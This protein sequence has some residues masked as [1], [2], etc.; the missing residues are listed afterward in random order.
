V[1][2]L[3]LALY[4]IRNFT[5]LTRLA[6]KP[7]LNLI[8][9]GNGSGKS[10]VCD[11]LLS[12]LA[13]ISDATVDSLKSRKSTDIGQAGLIFKTKNDRVYRLIRDFV[14]RKSSLS[15]LDS[16][17]KFHVVMQ[18]EEPI[19]KFLTDE[20]GG[21]PLKAFEGLFTMRASWMPSSRAGGVSQAEDRSS[22]PIP[23]SSPVLTA[24]TKS[25]PQDRAQKQKR[26]EE[27]KGF[28]TQGD[29]LAAMEDRLSDLQARSA[30]SKRRLRVATEKTAELTRLQ[31]QGGGFE[32]LR[33]LPDDYPLILETSAQ[34]EHLKN[35]QLATIAEEEEFLKQD[36][37]A[38]PNQPFFLTKF[39]I[40][41]GVLVLVSL[42]LMVDLNL[43]GLFQHL[44]VLLM[45]AGAGLMGY[46]GY[47][48]FGKLNKR[49]GLEEKLREAE[50][51]RA[52]AEAVFKKEN[53][54]C[55]E[56]LK[57]TGSANVA[58]LKEKVRT[59]EQFMQARR[60]L[61]SQRDQ[62]LGKKTLEELQSDVDTLT[63]QITDLETKLKA[64][65]TL[66]SDIYLIQ[67]E[68]RILE[69]ELAIPLTADQ[70]TKIDPP[71]ASAVPTEPRRSASSGE[72]PDFVSASFRGG[73]QT[74]PVQSLLLDRRL[75]L[76]NRMTRLIERT[77]GLNEAV[78]ILGQDLL[79]VLTS[80][81]NEPLPWHILS[82]GQQDLCHMIHQLAVDQALSQF[83]PFPLILDN[84]LPFLD[85]P[86]QL[87]VLD[88]L[89]EIAQNTQ[90]LLLSSVAYP[91]RT[92]DHLIVLK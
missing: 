9:G 21:L 19:A 85:P 83:Y 46:A 23:Q 22:S 33:G 37:A 12:V 30:E 43:I 91:N 81:T 39:F 53:A 38:I 67:E 17:N 40:G 59:Y 64:S 70:K 86:H 28:L 48:D 84:P 60:E 27:L 89:R 32:S 56:L 90:I 24:E 92:S 36:M 44:L 26:L 73:L 66:P 15:E 20:N 2:F 4:G 77:G 7:G 75:E 74:P 88:I 16:S 55:I 45:L 11:V 54:P 58:S 5:Q 71:P 1:V 10:T 34:Q 29:R 76:S 25:I 80:R 49:K 14:G 82:S 35:E 18:G 63:R 62:F 13:S 79:P 61:E 68:V 51:Q 8:Q 41:G 47:L 3:E 42:I 87:M 31:Q 57:K 65:S 69:Q 72:G 6:F 52:R 78:L 50:R